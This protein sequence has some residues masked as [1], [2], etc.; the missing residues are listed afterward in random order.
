MAKNLF[1]ARVERVRRSFIREILKVTERPEV[2]SFAGGLPKASLFPV[3]ELAEASRKVFAE[4]GRQALQYA[5][6]EGYPPL[7]EWIAARYQDRRGMRVDPE[8]VV[9]TTGSQQCL[10]L[11][12]KCFI[13]PGDTVLLERPGYLGAIQALSY[14][15][16]EFAGVRLADDG[17]DLEEMSGL[18]E[19]HR[20]KLFYAVPNFQ[21][22]SGLSYGREKRRAAG[23]MLST[24]GTLLLEDDPY[25]ELR[26]VGRDQ[27]P[28]YSFC[29]GPRILLGS[30]SKTVS[31]GLRLGWAVAGRDIREKLTTAKQAAD[32]HS[33]SLTQR[34]MHAYLSMFDLDEHIC[35]IRARYGA[36]REAMLEAVAEHFPPEAHTTRP[37][38]GM[39]LW[40]TLPEGLSSMALFD[41]AIRRE[42]A[43]VPGKPFY[44]DGSGENTLRLNFSNADEG[45][46]KE[47]IR[48]LGRCIEEFIAER[49]SGAAS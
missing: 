10:D 39:F 26:Y 28:V 40:V 33:S 48:R 37:E 23:E 12:A 44:V 11:V 30:F 9:I 41:K 42:V 38:G 15:D 7:R 13:D 25:G 14:F 18:I 49:Q 24:S 2:I 31:P 43:F 47:G 45:S 21:N 20:P 27:P 22:P 34:I 29:A 19:A 1:S 35:A 6:T 3:E 16:P 8:D 46:I 32:L 5:A 17:P 36:Q 4:Q